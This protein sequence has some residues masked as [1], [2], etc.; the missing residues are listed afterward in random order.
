MTTSDEYRAMADKSIQSARAAETE[1]ERLVYL[2]LAQVWLQIASL[3]N[4]GLQV[5]LPPAPQLG[6]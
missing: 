1:Q 5:G 6:R 3:Q 2:T 4:E